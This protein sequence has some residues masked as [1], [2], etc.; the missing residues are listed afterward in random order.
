MGRVTVFATDIFLCLFAVFAALRE[1]VPHYE[2]L[3]PS[4]AAIEIR[5]GST[6]REHCL[7]YVETESGL[8][9]NVLTDPNDSPLAQFDANAGKC[10]F[11]KRIDDNELE[12]DFQV[13]AVI[14]LL[15]NLQCEGAVIEVKTADPPERSLPNCGNGTAIFTVEFE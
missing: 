9:R 11:R 3:P 5:W 4:Y 2:F 14:P 12:A 13:T 10:I 7:L 1:I 15:N 6:M 8:G